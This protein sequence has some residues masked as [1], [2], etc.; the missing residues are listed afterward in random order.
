MRSESSA[1]KEKRAQDDLEEERRTSELIKR[2][3]G[4]LKREYEECKL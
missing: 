2:D 4:C 3:L 1:Q